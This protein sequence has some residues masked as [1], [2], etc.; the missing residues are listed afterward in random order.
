[1]LVIAK[2]PYKI[3]LSEISKTPEINLLSPP[4]SSS[5]KTICPC[6]LPVSL[7]TS[8]HCDLD[9]SLDFHHGQIILKM[10]LLTHPKTLYLSL[11][12]ALLFGLYFKLFETI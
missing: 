12:G 9:K 7:I 4:A 2:E 8:C 6:F 11:I 1:M 10:D 3:N 5:C